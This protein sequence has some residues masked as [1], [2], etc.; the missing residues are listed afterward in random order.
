MV[1]RETLERPQRAALE[2]HEAFALTGAPK[3][4]PGADALLCQPGTESQ[5]NEILQDQRSLAKALCS[6]STQ[7]VAE[8][9][10]FGFKQTWDESSYILVAVR[11]WKPH[12]TFL[13]LSFPICK[14]GHE[15]IYSLAGTEDSIICV[16]L[17]T[18]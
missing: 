12:S 8:C 11:Y 17:Y 18:P 1:L 13:S 2:L 14:K 3:L 10:G 4:R 6:A 9:M 16:W 7:P 5:G 15:K